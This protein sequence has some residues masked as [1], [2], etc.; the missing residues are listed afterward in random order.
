MEDL[1]GMC[2]QEH[3]RLVGMLGLYCGDHDVAEDL[4]QEAL[5]RLCRDWSRVR[6]L[7]APERWLHRVA[8]NLAHSHYRR[9]AIERKALSLL[10][11]R[12]RQESELQRDVESL[13]LLKNLPHRQKAALLLH[14]YLDMTVPEV[15]QVMEIPDGTAKTLIHRGARALSADPGIAEVRN[16]I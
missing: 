3:P 4:A 6:K 16:E 1:F 11:S 10:G 13:E 14:Y 15:A 7:H 8:I 12:R 2:Q 5:I 9:K